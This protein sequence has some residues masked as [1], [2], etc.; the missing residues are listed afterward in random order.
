MDTSCILS[1]YSYFGEHPTWCPS[2]FLASLTLQQQK[3]V[4]SSPASHF[5][6][7]AQN[8]NVLEKA[9]KYKPVT[10]P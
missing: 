9:L 2:C 5:S 10:L 7:K 8:D 3:T 1:I 6:C 4:I